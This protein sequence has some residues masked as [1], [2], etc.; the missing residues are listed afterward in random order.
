MVIQ[1]NDRIDRKSVTQGAPIVLPSESADFVFLRKDVALVV[2]EGRALNLE[3]GAGVGGEGGFGGS[4]ANPDPNP[5]PFITDVPQLTDIENITYVQYYDT[6]NSIRIKA[7]IKVRNSSKNKASVLGVD[8]R[9]E[10]SGFVASQAPSGFITPSPSVP[11]VVFDRTG[12][13]IAWGWNNV[14]GLG[15]YSSISYEWIISSSSGSSASAL[16]SGSKSYSTSGTF[17]VGNSGVSKTYRVSSAEGDTPATSSFRWLR[18]RA[19][20]TGTDGKTY[21]SAFSNPI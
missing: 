4:G 7:I 8:A 1:D 3:S 15:S 16:D 5:S 17:A 13:A 9:N 12:T 19:V 10:P 14:T 21:Y 6:F 11:S 20:I 2:D 18:V